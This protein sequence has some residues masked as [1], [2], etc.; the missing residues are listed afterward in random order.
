MS[1]K[2]LKIKDITDYL[3]SIAPLAYQESYDNAGLL[4]G[5]PETVIKSVLISLDCTE[6][7][8]DEAISKKCNFIISHHPI[9]F[10]FPLNQGDTPNLAWL[11]VL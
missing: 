11:Y 10:I 9:I 7:I 4:T 6:D 5:N 8:V 3:E 1:T 2:I